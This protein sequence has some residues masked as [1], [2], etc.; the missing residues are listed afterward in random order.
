M[1]YVLN[2]FSWHTKG[3][4]SWYAFFTCGGF[5]I[6]IFFVTMASGNGTQRAFNEDPSVLYISIHRY[7]NGQYYPC[8]PF[9]A[10][11]SCGEGPGLG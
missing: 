1:H 4:T 9:G 5:F 11:N 7:D 6:F 10:M 8:G 3:C 2:N